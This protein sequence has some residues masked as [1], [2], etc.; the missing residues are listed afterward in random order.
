MT[1][2]IH[3]NLYDK[4]EKI[5]FYKL[6]LEVTAMKRL[7]TTITFFTIICVIFF[8]TACANQ[9]GNDHGNMQTEKNSV[10]S[11]SEDTKSQGDNK[12]ETE[13]KEEM[14]NTISM[15]INGTKV[16]ATLVDNSSTKEL[17]DM[18]KKG[19]LTIEMEDYADMEKVGS[20]GSKLPTNDKQTTTKAGDLILYVGNKFVIYYDTNSWNFTRLGKIND[21][22]QDE[23]KKIL[24]KG[25]ATVTLCLD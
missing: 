11:T 1:D 5:P 17:L 16:T 15:D 22:S 21:V 8:M 9:K 19:P 18:L 12:T 2:A 20:I 4:V 24:G 3:I 13:V 7:K 6:N 23:L 25:D 14:K 10:S